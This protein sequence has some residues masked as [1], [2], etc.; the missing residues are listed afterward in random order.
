MPDLSEVK[1]VVGEL[2]IAEK[3]EL[4]RMVVEAVTVSRDGQPTIDYVLH[5]DT[6]NAPAGEPTPAYL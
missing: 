5:A 4:L 1:D 2:T 6:A 3:K